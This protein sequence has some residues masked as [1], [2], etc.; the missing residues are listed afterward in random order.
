MF[1][2]TSWLASRYKEWNRM[3]VDLPLPVTSTGDMNLDTILFSSDWSPEAAVSC[4][5]NARPPGIY[6]EDYINEIFR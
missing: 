3:T 1:G 4:F 6:K 5:A 2:L